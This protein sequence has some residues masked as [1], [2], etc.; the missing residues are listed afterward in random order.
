[1]SAAGLIASGYL[2]TWARLEN[3]EAPSRAVLSALSTTYYLGVALESLLLLLVVLVAVGVVFLL[4][5][6]SQSLTG[7]RKALSD[8]P[9]MSAWLFLGVVIAVIGLIAAGW[10][11]SILFAS[12]THP[13]YLPA[14]LGLALAVVVLASF[15]RIVGKELTLQ[16]T[17]TV[18]AAVLLLSTLSAVGFKIVDAGLGPIPFPEA[19]AWVPQADCAT[20]EAETGSVGCGFIGFYVG[21][22]RTWIYLVRTP[23]NCEGTTHFPPRLVLVPHDHALSLAVSEKLRADAPACPPS[24]SEEEAQE[25]EEQSEREEM[26]AEGEKHEP[27]PGPHH[28]H[29]GKDQGNGSCPGGRPH[30][31]SGP[32]DVPHEQP[33]GALGRPVMCSPPA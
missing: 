30:K 11:I 12:H 2:I 3:V 25:K 1:M 7:K 5:L 17:K 4:S 24:K 31:P 27:G 32:L 29:N 33:A 8:W 6:L 16:G 13:S 20:P 19:A 10:P 23:L 18:A 22:D 26:E 9:S 15:V 21:E 28:D 14:T